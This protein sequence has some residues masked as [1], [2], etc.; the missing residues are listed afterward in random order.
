MN[1]FL[2]DFHPD[3][4]FWVALLGA[5]CIAAV[6]VYNKWQER[7]ARRSLEARFS[8]TGPAQAEPLAAGDAQPDDPLFDR[9]SGTS[10]ERKEPGF[11]IDNSFPQLDDNPTV[12]GWNE[13]L[14]NSEDIADIDEEIHAMI[15]LTADRPVSGERI[16]ASLKSLGHAGKQRVVVA[17]QQNASRHGPWVEVHPERHYETIVV[18]V[19]LANRSGPLN[20]I[21]YSQCVATLQQTAESMG[22]GVDAPDMAETI[23]RARALDAR[24]APLD[25]Q[26]GIN[27]VNK[28]GNW[29]GELVDACAAQAGLILGTDGRYHAVS[30]AGDGLFTLQNSG[31]EV[32]RSHADAGS[33]QT[34]FRADTL[35]NIATSRLTLVL[36]LP[37]VAR[38][39]D[40]YARMKKLALTLAEELKGVVADD[41]LRPLTP[42]MLDSIERDIEPV[43][44][45]LEAAGFPAGSLRAL[46]L[47]D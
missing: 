29:N 4:R 39:L 31:S 28:N 38:E 30:E 20:E 25:A 43:Y 8:A 18:A 24:C 23:A 3:L 9:S 27:I 34:G 21:E 15:V 10:G 33:R 42:A 44:V 40:P 11:S 35:K 47:F 13:E 17:A 5:L 37:R 45:K 36:D 19:K 7:R 14:A 6:L 32:Q 12:P 41:D 22:A 46:A 16:L 1:K 26:I 2:A